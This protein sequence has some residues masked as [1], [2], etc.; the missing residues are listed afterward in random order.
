[1]QHPASFI[2]G[3]WLEGQGAGQQLLHPAT[4]KPLALASSAGTP[5]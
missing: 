4:E 2:G 3:R 5:G 1:M